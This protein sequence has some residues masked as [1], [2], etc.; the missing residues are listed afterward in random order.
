MKSLIR[1]FSSRK[2]AACLLTGFASGLP[3]ALTA[4]TLQAWMTT[5]HV[6]IRT[7]GLFS[8]VGL[9]YAFKFVWAPLLDRFV[10]PFLGHRRGWLLIC[11]IPLTVAIAA[12]AFTDP[13]TGP[14]WV[15]LFAVLVA[16]F[17]ASQDSVI[18]AYRTE[19]LTPEEAGPG[20]GLYTLGYRLALLVSG[21]FALFLADRI[22]WR[23]VY[24]ILSGVM[25]FGMST[26]LWAPEPVTAARP[27][28]K[29]RE[30]A[31]EPFMEFFKR[32]GALEIL[33]FLILYKLDVV[34]GSALWTTFLLGLNFTLTDLAAV[35]KI[36]GLIATV[37]GGIAG[38]VL[39][40]RWGIEK[41][42]WVFGLAQGVS[43]L[44]FFALAHYGHVYWLMVTAIAT[45]NLCSGMG[46][47][48]YQVFMMSLVNKKFTATEYALLTSL[49]AATRYI[50]QAPSGYLQHAIGWEGYF[51]VATLAAIP[52]LLLLLRFKHWNRPGLA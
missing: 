36:F 40:M 4:S 17:S 19:L 26:T 13:A 28:R 29:L 8:L 48:A 18:D 43:N 7:I 16:F 44:S 38:G 27:P 3:F 33:G 2:M 14:K 11:Q 10:P 51:L 50:G 25:L 30:A 52:G 22:P 47:T 6:D 24:L 39:M 42:L 5:V 35:M 41:S 20:V 9:P 15:A 34:I 45:E 1:A 32:P 46:T 23:T 49:M 31:I 21:A 12:M 37:V